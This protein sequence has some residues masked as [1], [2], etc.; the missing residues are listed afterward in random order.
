[1]TADVVI[2]GGG[3]M[4]ASVAYHLS[5]L[6][7]TQVI[8][9]ERE[10]QLGTGSTARNAGGVRHQ[11]SHPAN[12]QLSIESIRLFEEFENV[13][14]APIDFHQDGYLFLLSNPAHVEAFQRSAAVQRQAGI[15]IDWLTADEATRLAPGL[16]TEGIEAATFCARDGI[17][18]PNGVTMG[19][20]AAARRAGVEIRRGCEVTGILVE[21]DRVTGVTTS[22]GAI[23]TPIVVN[24]AGP[25]AASIGAMAGVALPVSPLRRHIFIAAPPP[26]AV[27]PASRI[28]VIDFATSF[29][30]HREG[31]H[32]L[33]GMGD[34]AEQ[35]AFD[36]SVNWN[37]L[38]DI[39][40][41]AARRLPALDDASI[42]KAW[43]GLYEMTPDAMPIIGKTGPEGLFTIAGFS[44]H[45]FQHSPAAGRIL[46]DVIADRDPHFDLSPFALGRFD[47]PLNVVEGGVV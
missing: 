17:C 34:P 19:F 47:R 14:G 23:T 24:A 13:V 1:M 30:F 39:A 37:V 40:P 32:V 8:L 4:G 18:D 42:V 29:Y 15:A 31:A 7:L 38:N 9:L 36:I 20:V 10:D 22:T 26:A 5:R 21:G 28:M 12:I 25:W 2:I 16:G 35:P 41:V 3:C 11:F 27:W 44:G 46:A 33:F 6:G 45:G 43:A